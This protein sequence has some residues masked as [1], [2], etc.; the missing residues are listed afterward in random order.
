M[1]EES[2]APDLTFRSAWGAETPSPPRPRAELLYVASRSGFV[3]EAACFDHVDERAEVGRRFAFGFSGF[4]FEPFFAH[5]LTFFVFPFDP[6]EAVVDHK[7]VADAAREF[8]AHFDRV[9][10]RPERETGREFA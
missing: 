3:P 5:A 6:A 9:E 1:P 2:T 10:V 8:R 7:A 4:F